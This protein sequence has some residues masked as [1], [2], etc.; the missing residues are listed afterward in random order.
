MDTNNGDLPI[1]AFTPPIYLPGGQPL[2]V[3]GKINVVACDCCGDAD[4]ACEV[5]DPW[6][7]GDDLY[8]QVE[9][10]SRCAGCKKN[11][12]FGSP[13]INP[14]MTIDSLIVNTLEFAVIYDSND[15]D[16]RHYWQTFNPDPGEPTYGTATFYLTTDD[17]SGYGRAFEYEQIRVDV[18][19]DETTGVITELTI[20]ITDIDES[21]TLTIF[22]YDESELPDVAIC[23]MVPNQLACSIDINDNAW[24]SGGYCRVNL[25]AA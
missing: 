18:W 21:S 4:P 16:I 9:D 25:T 3:G 19:L 20:V 7:T 24:A 17:C 5:P 11:Y 2:I 8:V 23:Q 15:G 13:P 14:S 1:M 10:L 6:S 22:Q 12:E